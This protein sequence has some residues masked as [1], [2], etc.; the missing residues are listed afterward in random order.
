M[1]ANNTSY[2]QTYINTG[3]GQA[4][5]LLHGIFGNV[6][7]W[8]PVVEA[9]RNSYQ[10]IVP[11]IPIRDL[12]LEDANVKHVAHILHEFIEH[13]ALRNVILVGHAVGG[14]LA[15]IYTHLYPANVKKLVLVSSAGLMERSALPGSEPTDIQILQDEFENAFYF[16]SDMREHVSE[17]LLEVIS[18]ESKQAALGEIVR[19]SK[20]HQV[21]SFLNKIDHPVLLVWGLLDPVSPPESALHFNDL[22]SNSEIRF[23][24]NCGHVPMIEKPDQFVTHLLVFLKPSSGSAWHSEKH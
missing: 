7:I 17:E 3:E 11:R 6:H 22:L 13:H 16:R 14:Q 20:Q 9:L 24:E 19:S 1:P 10:V 23:I 18:D 2:Y 4:V 12:T 15:L 5:I 21:S 8:K